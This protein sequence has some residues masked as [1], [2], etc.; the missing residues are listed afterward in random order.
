MRVL[1]RASIAA[2]ILLCGCSSIYTP[3]QWAVMSHPTGPTTKEQVEY[4][5]V[6]TTET[7]YRTEQS[8]TPG[9]LTQLGTGGLRFTPSSRSDT[10]QRRSGTAAMPSRAGS[11]NRVC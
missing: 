3:E 8:T 5:T 11:C 1:V 2:L 9:F 4:G 10:S 6:Y 7:R